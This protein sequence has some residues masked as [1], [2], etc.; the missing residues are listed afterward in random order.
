MRDFFTE[1][2][3][4][5][6]EEIGQSIYCKQEEIRH[7]KVMPGNTRGLEAADLDDS[8]WEDFDTAGPWGGYGEYQW[9]RTVLR[10]PES[11]KG[12]KT[13]FHLVSPYDKAWEIGAE[14]TAYLNGELNQ[15]LDF[16][17]HELLLT[18][19]A[20]GG[21][22]YSLALMGFNGLAEKRTITKTQLVAIDE[23]TEDLYYNLLTAWQTS[24]VIGKD[25]PAYYQ[26][27]KIVNT[28]IN[29]VDFRQPQSEQYYQSI[30][31]ANAYIKSE[32]YEKLSSDS[33]VTVDVIGHTHI[34][35]AWLW[36]L[37]HTK[38][39]CSR[40]FS[41]VNKLMD[42]YPDYLFF[43]SQPQLYEFVKDNYPPL[44]EKIKKRIHEERWEPDGG[45]WVEADCNLISGESMVRQ[46]LVGKAFMASEFG[47]DC[48]ILWLPDVFGYSASM[49]QI[50][51]KS[52]ISYFITSKISCSQFNN[53]PADSFYWEGIDGSRVITHFITTPDLRKLPQ[54]AL[55]PYLKTYNGELNPASASGSWDNYRQKNISNEV[56]MLFG[57]GDGGGGPTKEMLECAKRLKS[58]PGMPKVRI[59]F[60]SAFFKNLGERLASEAKAPVWVG[61]LYLETHR[62]TY[63]S[64]AA[65][66]RLNRKSEFLYL[67]TELLSSLY[68]IFGGDYPEKELYEGWKLIL[69]N[70]F[71]DII[72]GSSI[73]AVYEDSHKQYQELTEKADHLLSQAIE[74]ITSQIDAHWDGIVVFNPTSNCCDGIVVVKGTAPASVKAA[75]GQEFPV[76]IVNDGCYEFCAKGVPSKG[77]QVFYPSAETVPV[78]TST[79]RA[80]CLENRFFRIDLDQQ[81][82]IVS[83]WDKQNERQVLVPGQRGNVLQ[84]FEDKPLVNNNWD[85]DIFYS[86][87]MWEIN[88]LD[89]ITVLNNGPVRCGLQIK[90]RFLN[91]TIVQD[92]ILYSDI[93]RIDFHTR[94]DWHEK[95]IL[96]KA[97]FPVAVRAPRAAYEIQ[98]GSVERSTH[99]NTSWDAAKFEVCAHKWIDLSEGDYGVSLLND[100]KYGHDVCG[101][102]MRITLLK[103]GIYP[104]PDAD[105]ELH[106]FTYSLYPHAGS[107]E[108]AGT[109]KMAYGLNNPFISAP[110]SA[111]SGTLPETFASITVDSPNL[112]VECIKK[113]ISS[114]DLV[115]R[116]YEC[117]NT[118]GRATIT[119]GFDILGVAACDLMEKND[120]PISMNGRSFTIEYSN[121]EIL[122]FKLSVSAA[123]G[124]QGG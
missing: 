105:K 71:H 35:V 101:N 16:F 124:P 120:I 93:P 52:G 112:V 51:K 83:I 36:Q 53:M 31:K 27:V 106:E 48:Q 33:D 102:V 67:N 66:K 21:E 111:H 107:W 116:L 24:S 97:A 104:N 79:S 17:H 19:C 10:I 69:L 41:T 42:I 22:T 8:G 85:I 99:R 39:K 92:I 82:N 5:R 45:M 28:C 90:R 56:L 81:G 30:K 34:D 54:H 118:K 84:A 40:S 2:L 43:Q 12:Y 15:G 119:I 38:E 60:P 3:E 50:L 123:S 100:C 77:W 91:S 113:A 73:K 58:F 75:N 103:S 86:E 46:F 121:Y 59:C 65:N 25:L 88:D 110:I 80:D 62:G 6:I 7:Y 61:E 55:R 13:A 87:K 37:S 108:H 26:V 72:P 115:L 95:E 32:L 11:F 47:V 20:Q 14:Y 9:F 64:M 76:Q 96:L 44:Y 23:D 29:L 1:K 78:S 122:T 68:Y 18:S 74:G 63:T 4:R 89:S 98:Y 109:V 57:Y 114:D 49:P 70:Q 94:I 117:H